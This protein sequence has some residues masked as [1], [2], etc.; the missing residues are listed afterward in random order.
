MQ[1]IVADAAND[2][3]DIRLVRCSLFQLPAHRHG[4]IRCAGR[5][6]IYAIADD[7]LRWLVN[8]NGCGNVFG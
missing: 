3:T 7:D 2:R 5:Q 8:L 6:N 4:R 1:I